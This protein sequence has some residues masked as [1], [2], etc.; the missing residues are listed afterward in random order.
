MKEMR[1]LCKIHP[2]FDSKFQR[3]KQALHSEDLS[4]LL[5]SNLNTH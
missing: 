1:V 4:N 2:F 5:D 3:K